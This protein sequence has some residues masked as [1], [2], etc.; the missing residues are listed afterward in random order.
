MKS[1]Y[2]HK[3]TLFSVDSHT[4]LLLIH[5]GSELEYREW[6]LLRQKSIDFCQIELL[7][8]FLKC[9]LRWCF[10]NLEISYDQGLEA[11]WTTLEFCLLSA[12]ENRTTSF[13]IRSSII[14]MGRG[15]GLSSCKDS[16]NSIMKYKFLTLISDGLERGLIYHLHST[17]YAIILICGLYCAMLL[18]KTW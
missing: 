8:L 10:C 6:E 1:F 3:E 14:Q 9:H 2:W 4:A 7:K 17:A 15:L 18:H 13:F 5:D 16:M 11:K 12:N